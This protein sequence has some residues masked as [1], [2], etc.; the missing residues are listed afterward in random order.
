[1]TAYPGQG[2]GYARSTKE[3]LDFMSD[4]ALETGMVLDPVYS[5]KA[6]YHFVTNI[7]EA[8]PEKFRNT[9]IVFIHTGGTLGMFDKGDELMSKLQEI[10]PA[11][12]LDIYGKPDFGVDISKELESPKS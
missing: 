7:L 2:L 11:K 5:G 12:R 8:E 3:E 4:F 1:M 9:N 6:M 10:G